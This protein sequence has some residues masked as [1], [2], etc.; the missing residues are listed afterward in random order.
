MVTIKG[1]R[2]NSKNY[3]TK[4]FTRIPSDVISAS[5]ITKETITLEEI[6]KYFPQS[7][8]ASEWYCYNLFYNQ[9]AHPYISNKEF[10]SKVSSYDQITF[11]EYLESEK[12]FFSQVCQF[13]NVK[14][15]FKNKENTFFLNF[16]TFT[17][18][19]FLFFYSLVSIVY[20]T[21][22]RRA[23]VALWSGDYLHPD[24]LYEPRLGNLK[25]KIKIPVVEFIR[26]TGLSPIKILKNLKRRKSP[27]IYYSSLLYFF[28]L[29]GPKSD[30]PRVKSDSLLL[31]LMYSYRPQ[32]Q[33]E[34]KLVKIWEFI[35][36]SISIQKIIIWFFSHR[37]AGLLWASKN[38]KIKSIGFMH[39]LTTPYHMG[40][41]YMPGF[42]DIPFGPDRFGV[43]SAYWLKKYQNHS[44]FYP[45]GALQISGPLRSILTKTEIECENCDTINVLWVAEQSLPLAQSL[46]YL[47]HLIKNKKIKIFLKIRNFGQDGYFLQLGQIRPDLLT[48]I[49]V[50]KEEVSQSMKNAHVVV[51][52]HS[53]VVLE[54]SLYL[55]P[56]IFYQTP[57]WQDYF[58]IE[59]LGKEFECP[60]SVYCRSPEELE[61]AILNSQIKTSDLEIFLNKISQSFFGDQEKLGHDW[62][63]KEL[64]SEI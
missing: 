15:K 10:L 6:K 24:H 51:G 36:K 57:M 64:E 35:F 50:V 45:S 32:V 29:L 11:L 18:H 53:T 21:V 19:S 5:T 63:L 33:L 23:K 44:Q 62:I 27:V 31:F 37:T 59:S 42:K 58:N 1:K 47:D 9:M 41:E 16:K 52:S 60:H 49:S 54:S 26:T 28:D 43:W 48:Q 39:G 25:S 14:Y 2:R 56:F 22:D 34:L 3:E 38:L 40:H 13:Y 7:P 8:Y 46:P 30:K 55:K 17:V 12:C 20:L 4:S 61:K